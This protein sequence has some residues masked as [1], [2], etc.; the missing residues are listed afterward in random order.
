M[1]VQL[2]LV[3]L[4]YC[5]EECSLSH[6]GLVCLRKRLQRVSLHHSQKV[7]AAEEHLCV[8]VFV[9][10]EVCMPYTV[11]IVVNYI[12]MSNLQHLHIVYVVE[13]Q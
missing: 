11:T 8:C 12:C 6:L 10:T 7:E 4:E 1:V 13:A 2:N 5:L 9:S 3:H